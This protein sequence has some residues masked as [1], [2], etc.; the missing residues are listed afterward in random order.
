MNEDAIKDLVEGFNS[1]RVLRFYCIED[2]T[3]VVNGVSTIY[4][5]N[6]SVEVKFL[7][8]DVFEIVPTSN[9]SIMVLNGWPGPLGTFYPWLEGVKQFSNILFDMNPE[10]M[11][12]KWN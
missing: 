9:N 1:D 6:S 3:I 2:V 11:Y 7:E 10:E 12:T 4:P 5:A 8:T